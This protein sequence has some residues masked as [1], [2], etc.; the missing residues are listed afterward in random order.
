MQ[1]FHYEH[2]APDFTT[3]DVVILKYGLSAEETGKLEK[4]LVDQYMNNK[5]PT[6]TD[7]KAKLAEIQGLP[8]D[9]V[10]MKKVIDILKGYQADGIMNKMIKKILK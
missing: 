8:K 10:P 5:V 6:K 7:V 3:R 4:Y 9:S 2:L 1:L